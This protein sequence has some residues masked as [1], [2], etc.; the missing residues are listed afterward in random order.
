MEEHP[1]SAIRECLFNVFA[2][3]FRI[4]C[5]SSIRNLS[6]RHVVETRTHLLRWN[7]NECE[8]Y[9]LYGLTFVGLG[10]AVLVNEVTILV[11]CY[12]VVSASQECCKCDVSECY[13]VDIMLECKYWNYFLWGKKELHVVNRQFTEFG[14][15][16]LWT[17]LQHVK[18]WL[19]LLLCKFFRKDFCVLLMNWESW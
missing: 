7:C 5:R 1:L 19:F 18:C 10:E 4:G 2:A 6:T 11:K 12:G 8:I 13:F 3:T 16:V 9:K 17:V 14:S 15:T